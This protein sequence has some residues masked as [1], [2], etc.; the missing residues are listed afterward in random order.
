MSNTCA[1]QYIRREAQQLGVPR[2]FTQQHGGQ[3]CTGRRTA[4]YRTEDSKV[5]D[6]GQ[7]AGLRKE[8]LYMSL[9]RRTVYLRGKIHASA[10]AQSNYHTLWSAFFGF[11][12]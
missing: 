3:H 6:G 11:C 1:Q 10:A 7:P 12:L 4:Q 2:M 5:Q 9:L 8:N